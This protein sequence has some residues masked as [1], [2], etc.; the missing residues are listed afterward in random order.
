MN[1]IFHV[2]EPGDDKYD[3]EFKFT[4]SEDKLTG[5]WTAY[6][7]IDIKNRKYE[8][9]KKVFAYNPDIMLEQVKEYVDWN[10][11]TEKK[12]LEEYDEGEFEEWITK[13]FAS[14]TKLIYTINASNTLL[15]K[16]DVENL[17]KGDLT[18][19]RNTIYARHGYSF[20][21]RPL[22]VFFDAQSWYIP[23][24]TDIKSEFTEIEKENIKL[25]LRYEKNAIE[26][27]DYFG[28]G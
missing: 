21:N 4:I 20:K 17:K 10:T 12:T 11:F 7:N 16:N 18:I 2:K 6:K 26:Y 8:L 27:Y 5:K 22:R 9:T 14:A 23:V 24:H 1:G 19:I 13:E 15:K 28:R 3:G 25:L